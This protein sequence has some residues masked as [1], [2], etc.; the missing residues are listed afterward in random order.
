MTGRPRLPSLRGV[1]IKEADMPKVSKDSASNVEQIPGFVDD[2][3][4]ELDGYVVGFTTFSSDMDG[5]P[6]LRGLPNDECQCPH[7]GYVITGRIGFTS[8]GRQEVFEA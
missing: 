1:P 5:A 3:S 4:E 8:G 2:R 6:L 7:W